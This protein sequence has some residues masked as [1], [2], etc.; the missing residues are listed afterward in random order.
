MVKG[1]NSRRKIEK[2]KARYLGWAILLLCLILVSI[3]VY[4]ALNQPEIMLS[5]AEG[6]SSEFFVSLTGY[7]FLG[8]FSMFVLV[9]LGLWYA[10]WVLS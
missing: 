5:P 10:L 7:V 8:F 9:A 6:S 2:Q 4:V 1:Q 3:M